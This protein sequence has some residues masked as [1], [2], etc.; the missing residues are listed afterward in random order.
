MKVIGI[1]RGQIDRP[2]GHSQILDVSD[3][4]VGETKRK[5]VVLSPIIFVAPWL[6]CAIIVTQAAATDSESSG[7]FS[8][9]RTYQG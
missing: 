4:C 8:A 9:M 3:G 6:A 2:E 7:S 5:R 1:E